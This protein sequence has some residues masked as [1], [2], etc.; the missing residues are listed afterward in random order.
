MIK[1]HDGRFRITDDEHQALVAAATKAN[2][3]QSALIRMFVAQGL[4]QF[5]PRQEAIARHMEAMEARLNA[6]NAS[7]ESLTTVCE[8]AYLMASSSVGLL[9]S[10]EL[11]QIA[12][13]TKEA[14]ADRIMD[15]VRFSVVMG[16]RILKA[17]G[18]S[19]Q[20]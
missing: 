14:T 18:T 13:Q 19:E 16:K 20:S 3:S 10:L 8:N 5:D 9:S 11:P 17:R 4:A 6:L 1:S 7:V 12:A 2:I 15:N